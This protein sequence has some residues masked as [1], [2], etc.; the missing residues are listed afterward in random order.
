MDA[1]TSGVTL[2]KR[3]AGFAAF[4]LL[5]AFALTGVFSDQ[6]AAAQ[7][8]PLIKQLTFPVQHIP[9]GMT[10]DLAGNIYVNFRVT[11]G[12]GAR[13]EKF[14]AEGN[15][16]NF[17]H[18]DPS[19]ITGNAI[20]GKP[21]TGIWFDSNTPTGIAVDQSGGPNNGYIY[22]MPFESAGAI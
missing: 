21:G 3:R 4:A 22:L 1:C 20:Y 19:Y 15:P 5:L 9:L 16:V 13:F 10:S 14:D 2:A 18:V 7:S 17:T 6:A 12:S 8:R 11:D